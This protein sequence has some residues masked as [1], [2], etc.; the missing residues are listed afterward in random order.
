MFTDRAENVALIEASFRI[1]NER[2]ARWE[3][4]HAGGADEIYLCECASQPCRLRVRMSRDEYEAVRADPQHFLVVPGHVLPDLETVVRSTPA[5]EVIEKPAA[6]IDLLI[7]TDPRQQPT[8]EST[9]VAETL[10]DEIEPG[11]T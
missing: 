3:E 2:M 4:R 11:Q 1:A 5:Y 10:A 9:A 6:L 7:E 8:G